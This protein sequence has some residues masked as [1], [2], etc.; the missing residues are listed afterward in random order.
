MTP[1]FEQ[2]GE[3]IVVRV[4]VTEVLPETLGEFQAGESAGFR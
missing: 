1:S 2:A 3:E 4:G